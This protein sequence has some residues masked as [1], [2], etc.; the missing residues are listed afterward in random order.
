MACIKALKS[1]A[2][3]FLTGCWSTM[4]QY[5]VWF[6]VLAIATY[7]EKKTHTHTHTHTLLFQRL[8]QSRVKGFQ[9]GHDTQGSLALPLPKV[10]QVY[11]PIPP[12][13]PPPLRTL[14][15]FL[16][17]NQSLDFTNHL[18]HRYEP[19]TLNP[20]Q[21]CETCEWGALSVQ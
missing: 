6:W 10:F 12:M 14:S 18:I 2:T 11:P 13:N 8:R 9:G 17:L 19:Y 16:R 4:L 20:A 1:L 3:G 15:L 5:F 21:T 7:S